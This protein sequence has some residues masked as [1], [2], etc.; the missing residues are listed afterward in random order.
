MQKELI[1]PRGIPFSKLY[2]LEKKNEENEPERNGGRKAG[3]PT[4]SE[5]MLNGK[6]EIGV[7][8]KIVLR[9]CPCFPK[10]FLLE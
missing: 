9:S 2:G 4:V 10:M 8:R 5:N 6:G 3:R 1:I 7:Q